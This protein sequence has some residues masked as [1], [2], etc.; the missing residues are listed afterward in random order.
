[1]D[2]KQDYFIYPIMNGLSDHDAQLITLNK[3]GPNPPIKQT[4]EIRKFDKLSINDFLIKLSYETWDT[5]FLNNDVNEMF[6]TFLETYLKI[7]HSSFPL[8]KS[9][10]TSKR[11]NWITIAIRT[12]CKHKRELSIACKK[13]P[14][15]RNCYKKYC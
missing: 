10:I 14:E 12:A 7:F 9:Q 5:T 13:N 11:N 1:M 4:T 8:K 3:I 6:N 2:R 15:L